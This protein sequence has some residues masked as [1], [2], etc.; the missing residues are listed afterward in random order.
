MSSSDL[1]LLQLEQILHDFWAT[2][3]SNSL[4]LETAEKAWDE[5]LLAVAAGDDPLFAQ[6]KATIGP[7]YWTPAEAFALAFPDQPAPPA[8]LRV[9]S[10]A[11]P[12]TQATRAQQQLSLIH[13][14]EPTRP[15]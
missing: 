7:F 12:Q 6:V 5:P 8:E 9:I 11:L 13:I 15:Y 10:Y 2:A 1:N 14:S 3:P 4:H